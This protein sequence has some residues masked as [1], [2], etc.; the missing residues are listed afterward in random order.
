MNQEEEAQ[1]D[2]REARTM[3]PRLDRGGTTISGA[4]HG[5]IVVV[6]L[7]RVVVFFVRLFVS[8]A[9]ITLTAFIFVHQG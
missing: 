2:W 3:G 1:E 9:I 4:F 7:P 5:Q 6:V 8:P